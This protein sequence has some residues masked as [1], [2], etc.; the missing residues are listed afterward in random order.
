M[1]ETEV[2]AT[3]LL[4]VFFRNVFLWFS[5]EKLTSDQS[6]RSDRKKLFKFLNEM[7]LA[8]N[9][10]HRSFVDGSVLSSVRVK[11]A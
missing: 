7:T 1:F 9:F 4:F 8:G 6:I 11:R 5:L 2:I 10:V 3:D